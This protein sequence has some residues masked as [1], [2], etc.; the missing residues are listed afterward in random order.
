[1]D[2][3]KII[4]YISSFEGIARDVWKYK[5]YQENMD[6]ISQKD[7]IKFIK[8]IIADPGNYNIQ[9]ILVYK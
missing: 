4:Y 5:E 6:N 9:L 7:F 8:N 1:M 3:D 2:I